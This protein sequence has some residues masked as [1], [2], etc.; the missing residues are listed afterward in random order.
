MTDVPLCLLRARREMLKAL[1]ADTAEA[2]GV[3]R[4]RANRYVSEAVQIIE[5]EPDRVYDWSCLRGDYLQ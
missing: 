2:E 3:H 4:R 5:L 1:S